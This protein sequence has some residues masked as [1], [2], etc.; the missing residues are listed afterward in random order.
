MLPPVRRRRRRD[1]GRILARILCVLFAIVGLVPVGAGLLVR[2]SWARGIATRETRKVL[3]QNGVDATYEVGLRLWPLSVGV[4]N[5][6]VKASDGGTP[7]L[8]AQRAVARPK[9]FGLLAGKLVIDQIEIEKPRARVVLRDGKLKNL[10]VKLPETKKDSGPTKPPFSVVSASEAEIDLDVDGTHVVAK[11]IDADVTTDD[12]GEGGTAFEVALRLAEARGRIVRELKAPKGDD[13]GE[14]AVDEDVL[15]RVDGR[16][17]IDRKRVLVRR[18]SAHG[19]ADL[20][21]ADGTVLGCDL[22]KDDK[23]LVDVSLGHLAI[24]FPKNK[25]EPPN[26]DGHAKV[27]APLAL[28]DRFVPS[29]PEVDGWAMVDVE[30]R[31]TPETP[32]P[33]MAGRLEAKGLRVDKFSFARAIQSDFTVRRSVVASPLTRVEIAEGVAD[34]RDVEVQ[35]LAKDVPLKARVDV[36]D[37]SFVALM[38]DLGVSKHPHVTWDLHEVHAANVKGTLNPLHLDGDLSAH[39]TNFAVYDAAVDSPTKTRAT[40]VREGNIKGKLAI[41]PDA[42]QFHNVT[43][44]TPRGIVNDVLVSIGFHEVLR[45]EVPSGK[46][47]LAD[48]SPL[49]SVGLAGIAELKASVTGAF[50]DPHLEG[51][52]SI[53]SFA[54]GDRPEQLEF[55]NVTQAHV[56]LE[57][58]SV[59]LRDVRAQKGKSTYE[60]PTGRLDFGGAA[61]MKMESQ[62][63]SKNLDVREFLSVF[64]TSFV[65]ADR[66][67]AAV[68]L[69]ED[70]RFAELEGTIE[71]NARMRLT[72]GGPEDV[73]KGGLLDVQASTNMR[74]LNL[75]GEKFDEGHADFEYHWVDR[76]AGIEGADIEVRSLSLTKVK[77]EGRAPLGS[78]LGSLTV[79]RGGKLRGSLVLQGFPLGRADLLGDAAKALEGAVSGVARIGGTLTAYDVQ[80]D[81]DVTPVR[82][83]GAPFGGSNVHFGMTQKPP[84]VTVTGRTPC[85]APIT[86]PFDKEQWLRAQN[87]P[88]GA[89]TI[90]GA[91]FGG[92]VK[93]DHVLVTRQKAPIVNGR[94]ELA[95]F[96][97][98]PIGKVIV[99]NEEEGGATAPPL[100]GEISGEL[101][102]ERIPVADIGHAQAR[103]APRGIRVTRGGQR[104]EWRPAPVVATLS[105]DELAIPPMTFELAAPNGFKGAFALKGAVKKVT[106]GGELALD[107]ELAPIDL[108]ILVGIV[109]R[110]NRAG[111]TLSGSVK[112]RGK[113]SAPEF[114]GELKVRRGEFAVKGAPGAIT[115]V[116]VD[117]VADENEARITRAVGHFLGGDVSAT[118]RMPL[119]GGQLG[120][121][122]ATVTARQ[123]F[124]APMEGVKATVDA[125]LVMSLNPYA[126]TAAGRLPVI[127]GDVTITAFEYNKPITLE[128]NGIAGGARRTVV[129]AYDP[130]LDAVTLAFDVRSRVPLRIR[131]NL[132]DAQL[133]IDPRGIHVS[134]TNQ[135]IGLRGELTTIAGGHFRVFANDFEVQKGTIRFEDPTRIAPHVDLTATT[136]YRRYSNTL[137]TGGTATNT[138]GGAGATAGSISG[139]GQGGSLWRIK[140]HAYGDVE[141]LQVDMTSD[142]PLSREDIFFL[143]TIGLTRA[144]V[145]QVRYGGAAAGLAFETIGTA[146]GVDRAVKQALP[147]IDDFRPG[148]AYSPRTGR[149][150]PNITVGR[151]LT[152]NVRARLTSGLAEDP[153]LRSTIEW[154]LNRTFT[155]E[156]S[157][158]RVN[159]VSS[160]N[161]GNFGLDF[162]WRLEFN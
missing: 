98:G 58:L 152:E 78:V 161:V 1:W 144:E 61:A 73:C 53:S 134:G 115:D 49:G 127:G 44:T 18:F 7:F 52:V 103:F 2:T 29:A 112:I 100:G 37:V 105:N 82:I 40:G 63:T 26:L 87:E 151:R 129:E 47:D 76:Q 140:L 154:R 8:T 35:P 41:R 67:I 62:I 55:G 16:A 106:A 64:S 11:G 72:L 135:R 110:L 66:K 85:G 36:K 10:D 46:V 109:P 114:D 101:L 15:C 83:F 69:D 149:V 28:V 42:L 104:L 9:I 148:T 5:L 145:D 147:V 102:M 137:A 153:Q 157:Y 51:D 56:T 119:K 130:S 116:D 92:Q 118:A 122:E 6:R 14:Y 141:N 81:V 32:I 95:R 13:E 160:S 123:L 121:A 159:T 50:N 158:D 12:D 96:D 108:G 39:T 45:V 33:D 24:V 90:D 57:G 162:R 88:Q 156:P 113:A 124:V 131:N 86:G 94:I 71:T 89:Y 125:D 133:V 34:I 74:K 60:M 4:S 107:A 19:A 17:R 48:L 31:Y 65:G 79:Q 117:L 93:L 150:E 138:T 155:V 111:G 120:V 38:Q 3:A 97:L 21:A 23:R 25:G 91:L 146:S 139:A 68:R 84:N 136:E 99:A 43:V 75:L 22:A 77:K 126:S 132:V 142:P 70:P 27:R 30:L 20:D 143:L 128:L 80:A 59:L 54:I